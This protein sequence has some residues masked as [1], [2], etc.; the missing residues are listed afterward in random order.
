MNF[1]SILDSI[2]SELSLSRLSTIAHSVGLSVAGN[3]KSDIASDAVSGN[4][5]TF[6]SNDSALKQPHSQWGE[7]V[8]LDELGRGAF[9]IVHRA[10]D[11]VLRRDVALKI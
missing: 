9:G 5:T 6:L 7:L 4:Q 2:K 8:I 10:W 3:A 11:P 1:R